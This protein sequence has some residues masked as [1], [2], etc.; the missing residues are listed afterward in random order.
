[1]GDC[2]RAKKVHGMAGRTLCRITRV[3]V[4]GSRCSVRPDIRLLRGF[5][6]S[7]FCKHGSHWLAFGGNMGLPAVLQVAISVVSG[8]AY[9]VILLTSLA[10]RR[11]RRSLDLPIYLI[12]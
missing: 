4:C 12:K 3:Q 8:S 6:M 5:V 7:P 9:W 1:M 11:R 2:S 10:G